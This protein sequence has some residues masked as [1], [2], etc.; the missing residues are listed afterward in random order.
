LA[1]QLKIR[2]PYKIEQTTINPIIEGLASALIEVKVNDAR[3]SSDLTFFVG[4]RRVG[5]F[6][7]W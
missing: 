5:T 1:T 7:T 3:D 6:A 4:P 2:I